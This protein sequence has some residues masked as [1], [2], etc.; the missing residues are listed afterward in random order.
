[1][2][3]PFPMKGRSGLRPLAR[4]KYCALRAHRSGSEVLPGR[5]KSRRPVDL[6][7]LSPQWTEAVKGGNGMAIPNMIEKY[8]TKVVRNDLS[9]CDLLCLELT[10]DSLPNLFDRANIV[11][12]WAVCKISWCFGGPNFA[13]QRMTSHEK[14]CCS[15]HLSTFR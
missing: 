9:F 15:V 10:Q 11:N 14:R 13:W 6:G 8:I 3:H 12:I 2:F 7:Q 4:A 1:M 5:Q